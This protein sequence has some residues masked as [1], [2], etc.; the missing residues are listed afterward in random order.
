MSNVDLEIG[1]RR[2]AVACAD[3]EEAHI[4]ALGSMID[5]K[6]AGMGG[7]A[8]QSE[9]RMLLF[10]ALLL[11]DELHELKHRG[12]AETT[13]PAAEIMAGRLERLAA[14]LEKCATHLETLGK[15]A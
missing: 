9:A 11:A 3:G 5:A 8:G 15:D 2:I 6:I 14:S 10:G 7:A 4:A 13:G 1:G 12:G